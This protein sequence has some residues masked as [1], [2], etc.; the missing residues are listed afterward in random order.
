MHLGWFCTKTS[1]PKM[2]TLFFGFCEGFRILLY[3]QYV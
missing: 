3:F 1:Y 2:V